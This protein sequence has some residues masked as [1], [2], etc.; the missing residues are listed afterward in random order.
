[1]NMES[2]LQLANQVPEKSIENYA[3]QEISLQDILQILSRHLETE[4]N[5]LDVYLRYRGSLLYLTINTYYD[6]EKNVS[7]LDQVSI[8]KGDFLD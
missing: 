3:A 4:K 7:L 8:A 1:M 6:F 2:S 5:F